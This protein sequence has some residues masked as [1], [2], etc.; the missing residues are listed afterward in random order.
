MQWENRYGHEKR[1]EKYYRREEYIAKFPSPPAWCIL[2]EKI[3]KG[4]GKKGGKGGVF[5]FWGGRTDLGSWV[6]GVSSSIEQIYIPITAIRKD[7]E[8]KIPP[9]NERDGYCGYSTIW[10]PPSSN[11]FRVLR[12]LLRDTAR[13]SIESPCNI[14]SYILY[15][16][17][18]RTIRH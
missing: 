6:G 13:C 12:E 18:K 1:K 8:T 17:T 11:I 4:E 7:Q 15:R 10:L 9:R 3:R 5:Y 16:Y 2:W 14:K